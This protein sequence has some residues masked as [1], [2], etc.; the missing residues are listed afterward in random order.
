VVDESRQAAGLG[1][2]NDGVLVYAEHV[3][4]TDALG[5][6]ALFSVIGHRLPNRFPHVLY[7]KFL[8]GDLLQREQ[9]PV[10]DSRFGELEQLFP[11]LFF[12]ID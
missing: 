11:E 8:G 12:F 3:A 9:T 6:V 1:G 4:A 7:H 10:V 5:V 2:V